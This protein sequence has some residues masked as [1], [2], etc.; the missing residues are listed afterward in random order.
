MFGAGNF[1]KLQSVYMVYSKPKVYWPW[2]ML[3]LRFI[4]AGGDPSVLTTLVAG[5]FVGHIYYFVVE[6]LPKAYPYPFVENYL[7]FTT[8]D[9]L[10]KYIGS[11]SGLSSAT[12]AYSVVPPTG[13][14]TT[15]NGSS[16]FSSSATS[17]RRNSLQDRGLAGSGT[18]GGGSTTGRGSGNF[19][20]GL[21]GRSKTSGTTVPSNSQTNN[22]NTGQKVYKNPWRDMK[23]KSNSSKL[24]QDS[25]DALTPSMEMDKNSKGTGNLDEK[26]LI[27]KKN[28]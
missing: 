10:V 15:S 6:I 20:G 17:G 1:L 21:F 9:L 4:F 12:T 16:S 11:A 5:Y 22:T 23:T 19:V 8:P 24:N 2:F 3:G 14:R 7:V 25:D 27:D 18:V 13:Q 28:E 26:S